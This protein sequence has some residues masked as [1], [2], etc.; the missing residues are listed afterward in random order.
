MKKR[1]EIYKNLLK[2]SDYTTREIERISKCIIKYQKQKHTLESIEEKV[3][4][5]SHKLHY[6]NYK[7]AKRG[8]KHYNEINQTLEM[9]DEWK[10]KYGKKAYVKK[11]AKK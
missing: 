9:I 5:D 7:Y 4:Y 10:N 1:T 8:L 2:D 6:H 11:T 3:L